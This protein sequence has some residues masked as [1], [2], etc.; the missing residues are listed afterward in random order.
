MEQQVLRAWGAQ[1]DMLARSREERRGKD[2]DPDE[3]LAQHAREHPDRA[4]CSH[5]EHER[6]FYQVAEAPLEPRLEACH[7]LVHLRKADLHLLAQLGHIRPRRLAELGEIPPQHRK[8]G[9]RRHVIYPRIHLMHPV[10]KLRARLL[11]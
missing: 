3:R 6:P 7:F 1:D 5:P 8:I 2:R 4:D 9:P 11:S 10:H